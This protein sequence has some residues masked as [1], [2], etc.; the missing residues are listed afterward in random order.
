MGRGLEFLRETRQFKGSQDRVEQPRNSGTQGDLSNRPLL[1]SFLSNVKVNMLR[2]PSWNR[3]N[4][5][6]LARKGEGSKVLSESFFKLN[7][8]LKINIQKGTS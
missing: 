1:G 3:P 2:F 6:L 5:N 8:Y 4:L 7:N